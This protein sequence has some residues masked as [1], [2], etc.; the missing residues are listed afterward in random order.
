[1]NEQLKQEIDSTVIAAY[2]VYGVRNLARAAHK[3]PGKATHIGTKKSISNDDIKKVGKWFFYAVE[4]RKLNRLMTPA[5]VT[6]C[7]NSAVPWWLIWWLGRE[8]VIWVFNTY[9]E[10]WKVKNVPS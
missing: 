9:F 8:L 3:K 7:V 4:D 5:E 10:T 1:M 6:E 2:R